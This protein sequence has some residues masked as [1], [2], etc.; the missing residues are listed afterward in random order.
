MSA[1][2]TSQWTSS[3]ATSPRRTRSPPSRTLA[4]PIG[5]RCRGRRAHPPAPRA[6]PPERLRAARRAPRQD[7][8]ATAARPAARRRVQLARPRNGRPAQ[9]L[10]VHQ[11]SGADRLRR[12]N[13]QWGSKYNSR[14]LTPVRGDV[15]ALG[16]CILPARRD[17]SGD[18]R[19]VLKTDKPTQDVPRY[20]ERLQAW[21]MPIVRKERHR[22]P[23]RR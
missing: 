18:F 4:R 1:T 10:R 17:T 12:C 9:P 15:A 11:L 19:R 2:T 22:Q 3:L 23:T 20:R 14:D 5:T 21:L 16:G 6:R 8:S 7:C 13:P